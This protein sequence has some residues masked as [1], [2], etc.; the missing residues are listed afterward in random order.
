[1]ERLLKVF[2]RAI[3]PG[4]RSTSLAT[5]SAAALAEVGAGACAVAGAGETEG[6][7]G[8]EGVT[9]AF[10]PGVG[11]E[12]SSGVGDEDGVVVFKVGEAEDAL[13]AGVAEGGA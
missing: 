2:S 10:V 1:M 3:S 11:A 7:V 5:A 8:V 4:L 9:D 12:G 6:V 13:A